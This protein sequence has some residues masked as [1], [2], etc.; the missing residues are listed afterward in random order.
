MK[1]ARLVLSV[2][3]LGG[4][5]IIPACGKKGPPTLPVRS[6]SARV[7]DLKGERIGNDIVLEGNVTGLGG[8]G[9]QS[10]VTGVR[11][12]YAQFPLENQPCVDCPI[13]YQDFYDLGSEVIKEKGFSYRLKERP[14]GQ[15]YFF[16][17]NIIGP[18][19]TLGP[20]SIQIQVK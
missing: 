12:Y 16:R 7:V 5:L 18:N 2:L 17:V 13:K 19:G 8:Q 10:S 15:T 3:L 6:V 4:L 14:I 11:V 1:V 20:P 9:Q